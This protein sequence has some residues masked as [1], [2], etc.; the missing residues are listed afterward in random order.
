MKVAS[1]ILSILCFLGIVA[2]WYF[3]PYHFYIGLIDASSSLGAI[4]ANLVLLIITVIVGIPIT[5]ILFMLML[6]ILGDY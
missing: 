4:L 1:I 3:L 2:Y 6:I 5:I